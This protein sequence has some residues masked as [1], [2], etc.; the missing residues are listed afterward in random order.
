M[1][2]TTVGYK[3][4]VSASPMLIEKR[5]GIDDET[6]PGAAS[7][8]STPGGR[9]LLLSHQVAVTRNQVKAALLSQCENSPYSPEDVHLSTRYTKKTI[10]KESVNVPGSTRTN[11][12]S[13][14]GLRAATEM[15][16][17]APYPSPIR[18][19]GLSFRSDDSSLTA[20]SIIEI[21][22]AYNF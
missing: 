13:I 3:E 10:K 5:N 7:S 19:M 21:K 11:T 22:S 2:L 6:G 1:N 12:K 14:S 17:R 9:I 4:L 15:A 18:Y 8:T 20:P 16:R